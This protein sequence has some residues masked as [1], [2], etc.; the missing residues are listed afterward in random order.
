[1]VT[2][3]TEELQTILHCGRGAIDNYRKAG[4]LTGVKLGKGYIYT[5]EEIDKFLREQKNGA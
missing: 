3:T 2:Y 1:M 4:L 5:K